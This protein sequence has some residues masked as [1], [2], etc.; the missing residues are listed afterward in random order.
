MDYVIATTASTDEI[1]LPNGTVIKNQPGSAGFYALAGIRLFTDQVLIVGGVGPEYLARHEK[2]YR[3]NQVSLQGL[4]VRSEVTPL[5]VITYFPDGTRTDCPNIGLEEFRA[6]DPTINEVFSCCEEG[7]KGLYVF[8]DLDRDYLDALIG[9]KLRY[10]YKLMWE[11]SEDACKPEHIDVIE[12]YLKDIDVFSINRHEAKLLYGVDDEEEAQARLGAASPNWVFFRRGADGAILLAD[13]QGYL[14]PSLKGIPVVDTTGGGNSSSG[15]VL[16]GLCEG[17][18]PKMAGAIG[19][20][21]AAAI[22]G[23]F[24]VPEE[25]TQEMRHTALARAEAL[26]RIG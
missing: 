24:G 8:K 11:I 20:A 25:F 1:H 14:C 9:G 21:A 6:L 2:W 10:G 5:T 26:C 12:S 13:G 17:Y 19:S 16:Y 15:A 23:Q 7:M 22:I 4:T 3:E 18:G